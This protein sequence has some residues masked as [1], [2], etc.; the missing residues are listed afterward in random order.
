MKLSLD[1][2]TIAPRHV[3][4][5]AE[6]LSAWYDAHPAVRRLWAIKD[7]RTLSVIV[8]LEP[9]MDDDDT[10]PAW[11]ACNQS[12]A[13]EIRTITGSPVTLELL[14]EPP[15]AEFEVELEGE[16]VV[17]LNWRDPTSFWKAD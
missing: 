12:W 8:T 3:S 5:E 13:R 4:A 14:D 1:S 11:F 9:A 15:V 7:E 17:A 16:I 6:A 2:L 10:Y